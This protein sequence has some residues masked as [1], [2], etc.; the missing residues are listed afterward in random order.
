MSR[1]C[2]FAVFVLRGELAMILGMD[3]GRPPIGVIVVLFTNTHCMLQTCAQVA[4]VCD[5]MRQIYCEAAEI[6]LSLGS[7][8]ATHRRVS[9][10]I[11]RGLLGATTWRRVDK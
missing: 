8:A 7:T 4:T 9:I 2:Q 11:N 5:R 1:G 6:S 10:D 3:C